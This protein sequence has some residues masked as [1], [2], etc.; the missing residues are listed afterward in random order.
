ML[1][2]ILAALMVAVVMAGSAEAAPFEDA[3]A[4]Y[5]HGDYATVLKL[6]KP[7]AEQGD[8]KAQADLGVMYLDGK[9][10]PPDYAEAAKW[11]RKADEQGYAPALADLQTLYEYGKGNGNLGAVAKP[12]AEQGN[13]HAQNDLGIAYANGEE[14]VPDHAEA[15]KWFRLAEVDREWTTAR[16]RTTATAR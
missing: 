16:E 13:A 11:L 12:L 10:V 2:R 1:K 7:L 3:D 15:M 9:G 6:L 8:A 5:K 14:G 4:A